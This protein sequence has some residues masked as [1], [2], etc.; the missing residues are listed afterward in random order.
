MKLNEIRDND[1]ARKGRMRLGRGIGSGKGKTSGRGGKG[2]TARTGVRINGFEGGQMPLFRRLP[3]R[4]FNNVNRV[5]FEVVNL[6]DLQRCVDA[7]SLDAAK[8]VNAEALKAAG[9]VK[10]NKDGIKLLAKGALKAKLTV[11]V[12]KASEAAQEAVKKAGG[13]VVLPEA[14]E[15]A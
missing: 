5:E 10:N 13:K 7:G 2:Q 6:A 9:L 1:G 12:C 3:K 11:E 15:A 4:G 14:K 8:P